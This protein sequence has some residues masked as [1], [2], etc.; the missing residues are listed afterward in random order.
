MATGPRITSIL[1]S[2]DKKEI[3]AL[4]LPPPF[5]STEVQKDGMINEVVMAVLQ[6]A[7]INVIITTLPLQSMVMY[8]LKQENSFGV[9]G[10]HL[11]L[12]ADDK[13]SLISIPL[14]V[15][16]ESYYYYKPLHEKS[17]EYK[18]KL[19]NLKKLV[20]GASKGENVS[21]YKKVG[22]KV[23]KTRTLS[24]FKKLQQGRVDFISLP[25]QT[26]KWFIEKKFSQ[27]QNDFV[28]MKTSSKT[29]TISLHFNLKHP[30]AKESAESF[31]K[32][33]RAI[34]NN[35]KYTEILSSYIK[36]PSEVKSQLLRMHKFLK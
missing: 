2:P 4:D 28:T 18:G 9:M 23:K 24:L 36:N 3:F 26:A 30:K 16:N 32:G 12:T 6:E 34:V 35:G 29:Q 17:L 1:I 20:Y 10:R 19:S 14:Y 31:K 22:I 7:K 21:A 5:I 13:K 8:Y 11:G 27:Y 33:L 15:A 25:N